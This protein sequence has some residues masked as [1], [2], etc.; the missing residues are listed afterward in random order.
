[1]VEQEDVGDQTIDGR[2]IDA[3]VTQQSKPAHLD[4]C[5]WIIFL[6]IAIVHVVLMN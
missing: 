2:F 5:C 4:F 1:M 3:L 6:L